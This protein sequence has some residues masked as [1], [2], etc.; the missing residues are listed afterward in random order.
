MK[1]GKENSLPPG[2][3]PADQVPELDDLLS[4]EHIKFSVSLDLLLDNGQHAKGYF[5]QYNTD[6]NAAHF[7]RKKGQYQYF[8]LDG[9]LLENVIGWKLN[10]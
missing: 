7:Q 6:F 2:Y 10:K 3:K 9:E 1:N 4:T 8:T 5:Q